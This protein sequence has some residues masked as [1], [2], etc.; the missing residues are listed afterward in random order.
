MTF[1]E[2]IRESIIKYYEG[3]SFEAY[4][5]A[6]GKEVKYTKDYFDKVESEMLSNEEKTEP[7]DNA[8]EESTEPMMGME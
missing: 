8:T 2:A 3:N 5:K 4:N 7:V 1:E 6:T